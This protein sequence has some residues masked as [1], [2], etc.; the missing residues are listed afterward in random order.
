[1]L[2]FAP[3]TAPK[4]HPRAKPSQEMDIIYREF[5]KMLRANHVNETMKTRLCKHHRTHE[6]ATQTD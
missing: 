1:M 6:S 2:E 5:L 3:K 4:S